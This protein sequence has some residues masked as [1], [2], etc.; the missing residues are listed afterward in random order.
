MCLKLGGVKWE[1]G[2]L[3][4]KENTPLLL[5]NYQQLRNVFNLIY[6]L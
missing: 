5:I 3:L 1:E 6:V 4:H 2:T